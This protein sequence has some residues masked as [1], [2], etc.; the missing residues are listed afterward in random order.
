MKA[1]TYIGVA[2]GFVLLTTF[3]QAGVIPGRWE[4]VDAALD[5]AL[6]TIAFKS[7]GERQY[8]FKNAESITLTVQT[9][10]GAEL[11]IPKADVSR[12]VQQNPQSGRNSTLF[13]WSSL[14]GRVEGKKVSVILADGVE[15][16]GKAI[17]VTPDGL[18]MKISKTPDSERFPKGQTLVPRSLI[19]QVQLKELRSVLW[20]TIGI[21]AGGVLGLFAY[22]LYAISDS[23]LSVSDS[24]RMMES[25]LVVTGGAVAGYFLGK[26]ADQEDTLIRIADRRQE[27]TDSH[28]RSFASREAGSLRSFDLTSA[29]QAEAE[30]LLYQAP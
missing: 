2:V 20:R 6:I 16:K 29:A 28:Y 23:R 3:L 19:H 7:G 13:A 21:T 9:Q 4:K 10:E 12:I 25:M 30:V 22:F 27:A 24:R 8:T 15:I 26:R 1:K 5:G 11:T 17:S 18:L 14:P